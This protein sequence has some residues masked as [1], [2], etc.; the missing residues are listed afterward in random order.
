MG[1]VTRTVTL[2]VVQ[3]G[4][5]TAAS[6]VNT[7]NKAVE[8]LAGPLKAVEQEGIALAAAMDKLAKSGDAPG[9]LTA[10]AAKARVAIADLK[11]AMDAA[12]RSGQQMPEGLIRGLKLAE[13]ATDAAIKRASA[14]REEMQRTRREVDLVGDKFGTLGKILVDPAKGFDTLATKGG[15]AGKALGEA[16]KTALGLASVFGAAVLAGEA[17]A[18]GMEIVGNKIVELATKEADAAVKSARI[19]AALRAA[20]KGVI[21]YD[22]SVS[23][24][25]KKYD[26][27]LVKQG[28]ASAALDQFGKTAGGLTVPKTLGEV[29]ESARKMADELEGAKKRGNLKDWAIENAREIEKMISDIKQRGG[30]IPEVLL[31]AK[32]AADAYSDSTKNAA[33]AAKVHAKAE[34]EKRKALEKATGEM[35]KAIEKAIEKAQKE[36]ESARATV[37]ATNMSVEEQV[38]GLRK[39]NLSEDE[40]YRKK[41]EITDKAE[42]EQAEAGRKIMKSWEDQEQAI[43]DAE[44]KFK[45]ATGTITGTLT[46]V[47][48]AGAG[49]ADAVGKIGEKSSD[50]KAPMDDI[51]KSAS[52][53]AQ[54]IGAIETSAKGTVAVADV[55]IQKVDGMAASLRNLAAAAAAAAGSQGGG[56]PG[57]GGAEPTPA[58]EPGGIPL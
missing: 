41:K 46:G 48:T 16:G 43:S 49:T 9:A 13:N 40:Y 57:G 18:K 3:D 15:A 27:Y 10:N 55:F 33:E 23:D 1:D 37:T 44:T 8:D 14:L 52:A 35:Q 38:A 51:A 20:R 21:D 34:E 2:R 53:A 4:A 11:N 28:L 31:E 22:G 42:G 36:Q 26:S 17:L 29:A 25:L 5:E 54:H 6:G 56:T 19:E 12:A 45:E 30:V 50:A 24:L 39:L 7:L 32:K 47:A 58:P